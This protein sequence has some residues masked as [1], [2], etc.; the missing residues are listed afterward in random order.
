MENKNSWLYFTLG[1]AL[2]WSLFP[3]ISSDALKTTPPFLTLSITL[4]IA[5]IFFFALVIVSGKFHELK[6][7]KAWKYATITAIFIGV[8]H[9]G[10]YYSGL[11]LTSPGNA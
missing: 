1:S 8:L 10:L 9:Y 6:N 4:L 2:L 7:I 3:I 5:S 11:R